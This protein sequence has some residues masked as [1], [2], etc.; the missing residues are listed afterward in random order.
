[1]GFL[2]IGLLIFIS[3]HM[4]PAYPARNTLIEKFGEN[5]YKGLFA[6]IAALGLGLIIYGK[7]Y[8]EFIPIWNPPAWSRHLTMLLALIATLFLVCSILPNNLKNFL[9]HPMLLAVIIW[10]IGHLIVNGD[11]ASII[12]FASLV[13]FSAL[14]IISLNKRQQFSATEKV[15]AAWNTTTLVAGIGLYG[16]FVYFHQYIAG[17]PLLG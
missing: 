8:S 1:M 12:L 15:T 7:A 4:L 9:R 5:A 3:I 17:V 11:L 16:F 2:I 6:L 14:K 13:I 10:G